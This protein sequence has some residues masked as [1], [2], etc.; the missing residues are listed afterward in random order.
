M[1]KVAS[2]M[3]DY[4]SKYRDNTR[5]NV[6][7][8]S[9]IRLCHE[10]RKIIGEEDFDRISS[11]LSDGN[12]TMALGLAPSFDLRKRNCPKCSA[13]RVLHLL[14]PECGAIFDIKKDLCLEMNLTKTTGIG[15][16]NGESIGCVKK[17]KQASMRAAAKVKRR[18]DHAGMAGSVTFNSLN[19]RLLLVPPSYTILLRISIMRF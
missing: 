14:C 5:S 15:K 1:R 16:S 6:Y 2:V 12:M 4:F 17:R 9:T 3:S 18:C 19:K 8:D 10:L 13:R 7:I 11:F